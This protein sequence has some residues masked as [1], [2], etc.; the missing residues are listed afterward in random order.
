MLVSESKG[1]HF[2]PSESIFPPIGQSD[3]CGF[4]N[5]SCRGGNHSHTRSSTSNQTPK[6]PGLNLKK[7]G[8]DIKGWVSNIEGTGSRKGLDFNQVGSSR[9]PRRG[10]WSGVVNFFKED[11]N[12]SQPHFEEKQATL[13]GKWRQ[14]IHLCAQLL[15]TSNQLASHYP[16]RV[17]RPK[18][19]STARL[20]SPLKGGWR[21]KNF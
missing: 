17:K 11:P 16:L 7:L 5:S 13:K 21:H 20:G 12:F 4:H 10:P 19:C 2:C 3:C 15:Q 1:V 14:I 6:K 9:V 18:M 8:L